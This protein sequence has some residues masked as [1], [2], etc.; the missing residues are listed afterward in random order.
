MELL[1]HYSCF[2]LG[3]KICDNCIDSTFGSINRTFS[4][5]NGICMAE[6]IYGNLN[7]QSD[8]DR[9][10]FIKNCILENNTKSE[11]LLA[12]INKFFPQYL[13]DANKYLVLK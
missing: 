2:A 10:I 7:R 9:K 12:I 3:I 6:Y 13:E 4:A 8:L 11:Y 5:I 1:G